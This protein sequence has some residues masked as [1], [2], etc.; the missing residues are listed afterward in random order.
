MSA[1]PIRFVHASDFH[2]ELPLFGVAQVPSHLRDAFFEAPYLAAERVFDTVLA[3]NARFLVLSGDI[4]NAPAAG[5]RG[6][7][8]LLEQ[9]R[10]LEERGIEVYWAGGRVDPASGWP[11]ATPLPDNVHVFSPNGPEHF[12]HRHNGETVALLVGQGRGRSGLIPAQE[13][14]E[15]EAGCGSGLYSI[16]VAHGHQKQ[17]VLQNSAFNYWALGGHHDRTTLFSS[18]VVAHYP[19]SPQGREPQETGTH[20][21]TVV[22]V[23]E[24]GTSRLS[25]VATDLL[26]WQSERLML[27]SD[28]TKATLL[29]RITNRA[30]HLRDGS[31]NVDQL[32]EWAL[33]GE[34]SLVRELAAGDETRQLNE[35]LREKFGHEHPVVWSLAVDVEATQALPSTWFE[36]ETLRGEYV[37]QVQALHEDVTD[38]LD[39][40]PYIPDRY[41]ETAIGEALELAIGE[42]RER[43]LH[44]AAALGAEL[45]TGEAETMALPATSD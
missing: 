23:D 9:F 33:V 6:V 11:P 29:K 17:P 21:C 2:L 40:T 42:Q 26:R 39:L 3:E 5:A 22:E 44:R 41:A 28:W 30:E 18:P 24:R 31:G 14:A 45:L 10:R 32:V 7:L 16:A 34:G 15:L 25:H 8:F 27:G 13:L 19:G 36:E 38:S 43:V 4:I 1:W 35:Q 20:G 12:V 37:R